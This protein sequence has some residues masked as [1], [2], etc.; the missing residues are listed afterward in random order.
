MHWESINNNFHLKRFSL[1]ND[2]NFEKNNARHEKP[3]VV[4]VKSKNWPL[5][6]GGRLF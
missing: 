5:N 4:L 1:E 6:S 3:F 2:L